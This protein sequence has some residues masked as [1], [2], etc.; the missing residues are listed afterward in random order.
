MERKRRTGEREGEDEERKKKRT[1][2]EFDRPRAS[3]VFL[4]RVFVVVCVF[5]ESRGGLLSEE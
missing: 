4:S 5:W 3:G 1:K 2:K